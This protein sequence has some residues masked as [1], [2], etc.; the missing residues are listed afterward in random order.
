MKFFTIFV[1]L[2]I[3][4]QI[5][6]CTESKRQKNCCSTIQKLCKDLTDNCI[7]IG[8]RL[9]N[10]NLT[11]HNNETT[12]PK[13]EDCNICFEKFKEKKSIFNIKTGISRR[14]I[15]LPCCKQTLCENCKFEWIEN[16]PQKKL[17]V[18]L[19]TISDAPQIKCMRCP[20][21]CT[22]IPQKEIYN[23]LL[24]EIQNNSIKLH[25][26]IQL[27]KQ[28]GEEDTTLAI[29]QEAMLDD[30]YWQ[31]LLKKIREEEPSLDTKIQFLLSMQLF[32]ET[33][34]NFE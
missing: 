5:C 6:N 15:T 26:Q 19:K 14:K 34:F 31:V 4:F 20:F 30:N 17:E 28:V 27:L 13:S 23:A 21:C 8:Q 7:Y 33:Y 25:E 9:R 1:S 11:I 10:R 22:L 32:K 12:I 24:S 2:E 3:M 29:L 18:L 16:E